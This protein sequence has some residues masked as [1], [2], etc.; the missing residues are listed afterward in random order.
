MSDRNIGKRFI[1]KRSSNTNNCA[2][3]FMKTV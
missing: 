3:K 1:K 2:N